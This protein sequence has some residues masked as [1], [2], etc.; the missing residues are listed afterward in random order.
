M[1]VKIQ[2]FV[3]EFFKPESV[4]TSV[5]RKITKDLSRSQGI[6]NPCD[7]PPRISADLSGKS[8]YVCI[9]V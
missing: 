3:F 4:G 1:F 2:G 7:F 6:L 5:S 8:I 9:Q